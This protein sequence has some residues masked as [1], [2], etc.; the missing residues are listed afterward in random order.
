MSLSIAEESPPSFVA[1]ARVPIAFEVT[2]VYDVTPGREAVD[3]IR[4]IER[5]LDTPW[6]KDYDAIDGNAPT[7]WPRRFDVSR[8]GVLVARQGRSRVGGAVI[9]FDAAEPDVRE[10]RRDL[11]ML[12]DMRVAPS[13]RGHGVGTALFEAA[14]AWAAG[15]GA[16]RL[17]I[18]TQNVNV[19]ACRFYAKQGCVLGAIHRFAY[20]GLPAEVQLLWYRAVGGAR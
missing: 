6:V 18:E 5:A 7:D 13:H 9:A 1:Y 16:R 4:L 11:A 2:R 12:W 10:E 8:W 20:P 3:G 15:R 19:P 17:E 14:I